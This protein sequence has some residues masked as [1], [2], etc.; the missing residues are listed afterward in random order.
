LNQCGTPCGTTTT[1]PGCRLR[2][3]PPSMREP[4]TSPGAVVF[5]S[6]LA[7]LLLAT[8]LTAARPIAGGVSMASLAFALLAAYAIPTD[9]L[10]GSHVGVK[11]ALS[12]VFVGA[13]IFF[14]G[15]SFAAL[16]RGRSEADRAF[17]WNL[18]GAVAGGLLELLSMAIGLKLLLVVALA[19]YLL[20]ALL[21]LRSPRGNAT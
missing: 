13:P 21:W 5:G 2:V 12:I 17:G 19:A 9:R 10:L 3:S 14:A 7:M 1:S 11:L 16:F 20:A 4:R 6:I 15:L 8:L 18:L